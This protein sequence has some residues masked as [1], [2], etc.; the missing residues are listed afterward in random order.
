MAAER[1]LEELKRHATASKTPWALGLLARSQA[2]MADDSMAEE[3]FKKSIAQ[4]E[5]TLVVTDLAYGTSLVRRVAA[6][7]ATTN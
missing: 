3:I 4:L 6:T 7:P 1:A 5:Q 2:L